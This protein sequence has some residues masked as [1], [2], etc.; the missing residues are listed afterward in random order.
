MARKP[1]ASKS[2]F[3]LQ[4][5]ERALGEW[6]RLDRAVQLQFKRKLNKLVTGKESPS[7]KARLSGLPNC[8]KIK[9]RKSGYRLVYQYEKNALIILVVAVGKRER[10]IVYD[11]ARRRITAR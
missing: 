3:A 4:F 5:D 11:A 8:Y 2:K 1:P 7:P 9:Q 6:Q 10:S